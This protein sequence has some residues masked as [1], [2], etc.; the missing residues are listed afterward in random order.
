ME[1]KETRN[2]NNN[3]VTVPFAGGRVVIVLLCIYIA[4][5]VLLYGAVD[6]G[7]LVIVS[8]VSV[9]ILAE[10]TRLSLK[11]R[12]LPIAAY[13]LQ[14]PIA[15]LFV[16][17]IVQLLPGGGVSIPAGAISVPITSTLSLDAY[18]TRFFLARLFL[19]IIFFAAALTYINSVPRLRSVVIFLIVFAG[20]LAFYS[21]LQRVEDPGSIYG[22]REPSQAIPFGTFINRHHF[23]ALM[24]MTLGLSLGV[25]LAGRLKTNR[26]PFVATAAV[27]MAIAIILTGSRGGVIGLVTI[28][29]AIA[30]LT[31]Y[32]A[33]KSE[34]D[35]LAARVSPA[36][37]VVGG[38]VILAIAI[39]LVLFLGG[40]D[41]LLRGTG[42]TNGAGD[43]TSGRTEFWRTAVRIFLDH[44]II[45]VGLDAFGVAYSVYDTSNGLVRVEQAHNDYLQIL[46]DAGLLGF[47]CVAAFV[48]LLIRRGIAVVRDAPAGFRRGAAIGALAGCSGLLV[49]SFFD[50]PLR[51]PANAFVF[52][53]LAAV[54]VVDIPEVKLK[55]RRRHSSDSRTIER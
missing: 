30:V 15:A 26:W 34:G 18:A 17:G 51:T 37:V 45:G 6:T 22:L 31:I 42:V 52:L 3:S 5:A 24:E 2:S 20:L 29:V 47:G 25:L 46:A 19:C 36:F 14:V 32:G 27:V 55:N 48:F 49:H 11:Y 35:D 28:L 10:W 8:L 33:R 4:V 43:F 40:A 23:A 44:P 12:V 39:G 9:L 13:Y 21:I 53:I 38:A 50:F 41:P 1:T 16:I 7:T 54:A